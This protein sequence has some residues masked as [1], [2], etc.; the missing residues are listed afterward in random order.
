MFVALTISVLG[1]ALEASAAFQVVLVQ[2]GARERVQ[3]A[4]ASG[5]Y[6]EADA[7]A[8][9]W[10]ASVEVEQGPETL[11]AARALD[12]LVEAQLK[13]GK[14]GT[15]AILTLAERAV[16]LKEQY[17][18]PSDVETAISLHNWG[19]AHVLRG[20]FSEAVPL[21]ARALKIRLAVLGP[22]DPA[23]ADSLDQLALALIHLEKFQEAK[24][25]LDES[26]KIRESQSA[27]S[28][29]A[30][31]RTLDLIG[32]LLRYSGS[33][34]AAVAPIDRALAIQDRVAPGHPDAVLSLELR[35]DIVFL[36]GDAAGAQRIWST[37]LVLGERTL[38]PEHPAISEILRRLGFAAF[39]LGNLAE[40]RQQRDRALRVGETA[41]APCDPELVHLRNAL[42]NSLL[43]D[44]EYSE[45][46]KV[47]QRVLT[48]TEKCQR[49]GSDVSADDH[50]TAVYNM[51]ALAREIGDLAEADRLYGSAIQIWS[52]GLGPNHPFIA[53]GLD[54][55]AQVVAARGQLARARMLYERALEIRRRSLGPDHP[56][57]GWT[58]TN[59]AR[60]VAD[61]GELSLAFRYIDQAIAIHQK[62]GASDE[63][64]HF[65][66]VLELRGTLE[67]RRGN[68]EA[69]RASLTEALVE[70]E[71]IFGI[72]HPLAAE[73]RAALARIDFARGAS[74]AALASGLE[75][76]QA[77]R[78]HLRFTVRYLPERQ[79]MA[80]AAKRPRGLD[81]ALSIAASGDV[82]DSARLFDAVI[83]S[84]GVILE[85]LAA[86]NRAVQDPDPQVSSLKARADAARQ[87]F[88]NLVVRSLEE[89][90]P[91]ALLDE[92]RQQKEG[93][94]RNL[95]ERS[96]EARAELAQ[97][98]TGLESVSRALR[99]N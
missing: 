72:A 70:R 60:T 97:A 23:V 11:A 19:T 94:E 69:A 63:P 54:A 67:A 65:A 49:N 36:M 2:D 84:R 79:A 12:L 8:A 17:L 45:A 95:A 89:P 31:A 6:V 43:F 25:K 15:P 74:V 91:R 9:Q 71:R 62:S 27:E 37:A 86:R 20:E 98:S 99:R 13:N 29:L 5:S 35:G 59:L 44:G 93:A 57:V 46:Q 38:G 3:R 75:A 88:A 64:D 18:G 85:E 51:A 96:V 7:L 61:M 40:A 47:Y 34:P 4:L 81:L 22:D 76:E 87:R 30:L 32:M 24:R 10:F 14:A 78:D 39:S 53:H 50:A 28:P 16:H 92:A 80:Y 33:Y 56:L 77:G 52:K 41:L 42:A 66:R 82:P 55:Y 90:V 48:T 58:L 73:T 68:L 26:L 83:Q 1:M 21:H